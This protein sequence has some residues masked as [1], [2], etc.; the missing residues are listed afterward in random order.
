MFQSVG[1]GCGTEAVGA[2]GR[3][4]DAG[5]SGVMF[6]GVSVDGRARERALGGASWVADRTEVGAI[7]IG[8]VT[9][10]VEVFFEERGGGRMDGEV[11]NPGTFAVYHPTRDATT[12]GVVTDPK[13]A[14]FASAE[15]V[16]QENR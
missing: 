1:G 11:S 4:G 12:R 6:D 13:P 15:G 14:K 9:R 5:R 7:G 8:A 16:V 2:D 3:C 10:G